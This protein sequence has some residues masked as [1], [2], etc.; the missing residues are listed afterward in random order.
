M[1]VSGTIDSIG[2]DIMSAPD[3]ECTRGTAGTDIGVYVLGGKCTR[4]TIG[5]DESDG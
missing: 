3:N 4:G 5:T 2:S 1:R